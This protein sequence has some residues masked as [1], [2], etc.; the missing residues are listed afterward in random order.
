[1]FAG[2]AAVIAGTNRAAA[3]LCA[4]RPDCG[5]ISSIGWEHT[6]GHSASCTAPICAGGSAR[7]F[8]PPVAATSG[9]TREFGAN[10]AVTMRQLITHF[11]LL[12]SAF[13][14]PALADWLWPH[15]RTAAKIAFAIPLLFL[16]VESYEV[17]EKA[18]ELLVE[19]PFIVIPTAIAVTYLAGHY[20]SLMMQRAA[21]PGAAETSSAGN[22]AHAKSALSLYEFV[23]A[24]T[25][26]VGSA[27]HENRK[28][29]RACCTSE[30]PR[31]LPSQAWPRGRSGTVVAWA[32]GKN[33]RPSDK[34]L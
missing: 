14:V 33:L 26:A 18:Y 19:H 10:L 13:S 25:Y 20:F 7:G 5:R 12:A 15:N 8:L 6:Q 11:V 30:W 23:S 2:K 29:L 31:S 28:A 32:K 4:S 24:V 1:M 17:G 3:Y 16:L 22:T 34:N 27:L 9:S 21:E